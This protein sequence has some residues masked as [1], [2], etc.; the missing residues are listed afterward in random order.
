MG[1]GRS[2]DVSGSLYLTADKDRIVAEGD[3]DAR[4]LL[5]IEGEDIPAEYAHLKQAVKASNKA[6][7]KPVNKGAK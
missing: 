3:A 4:F 7:P 5:C 2:A 6:A 1:R